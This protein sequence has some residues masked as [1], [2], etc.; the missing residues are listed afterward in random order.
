M[1]LSAILVLV[2]PDQIESCT[3]SLNDLQ[4]VEVHH[5]D[6]PTGRLIV[7]QEADSVSAEVEGLRRLQGLP[8][9]RMAELV[10]HYFE[11]DP[12]LQSGRQTVAFDHAERPIAEQGSRNQDSE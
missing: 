10:Y 6:P 9:V 8:Y 1:N 11:D 3:A 4:G 7:V 2:A 5:T 12:E